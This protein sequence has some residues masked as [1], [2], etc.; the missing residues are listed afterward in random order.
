MGSGNDKIKVHCSTLDCA[1]AE[2][3]SP[4]QIH[5]HYYSSTSIAEVKWD[6]VCSLNNPSILEHF[7]F[8]LLEI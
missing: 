3:N 1:S 4:F 8:L 5:H 2:E 6:Q 7:D